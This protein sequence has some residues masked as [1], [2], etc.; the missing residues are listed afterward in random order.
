MTTVE[1]GIFIFKSMI[2]KPVAINH[3]LF[4]AVT[5]SRINSLAYINSTIIQ[6]FVRSNFHQV[7]KDDR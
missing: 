4:Y 3:T 1:C 6:H 2:K 5:F 7:K